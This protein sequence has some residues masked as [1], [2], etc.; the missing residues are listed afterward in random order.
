MEEQE[1]RIEEQSTRIYSTVCALGLSKQISGQL[2]TF[3]FLGLTL[4]TIKATK[5]TSNNS[6]TNFQLRNTQQ[7]IVNSSNN[8]DHIKGLQVS[9]L[10]NSLSVHRIG[11]T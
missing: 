5:L 4:T 11:G 6:S 3:D 9:F 7:I 1:Y 8:K 2:H 10:F